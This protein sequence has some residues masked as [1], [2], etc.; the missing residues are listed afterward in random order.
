M[1][2]VIMAM[3]RPLFMLINSAI[4][5][6]ASASDYFDVIFHGLPL[7]FAVAGYLSIIPGILGIASPWLTREFS[8]LCLS[9]W[10]YITCLLIVLSFL[11]DTVLYPFWGAK[12]DVTPFYYFISSP[13]AAFAG[14]EIWQVVALFL[15]LFLFSTILF[16]LYRWLVILP[17]WTPARRR[18]LPPP[19][20]ESIVMLVATALLIIPIR[21]GFSVSTNNLSRAYYCNNV[22][23]NHAAV[24]PLFSF[25]Y[26]AAHQNN[27][28]SLYRFMPDDEADAILRSISSPDVTHLPAD[29]LLSVTRPDVYIVLMESF[30]S[31]IVPSQ[32]GER[33]AL[34]IDSLASEGLLF[35]GIYASSFRTDRG[36]PAVLS[37]YPGTPTTSIMR[38]TEKTD[39]MPAIPR[40]L[41][42]AGYTSTYF[43]GGDGQFNNRQAYLLGSEVDRILDVRDFSDDIPKGKWGVPDHYLIDRVKQEVA[44]PYDSSSPRLTIVQTSSSHEPFDVP[45][46]LPEGMDKRVNAFIY[47]DSAITSLVRFL[48]ADSARWAN[49]LVILVPDHQGSYPDVTPD[50][51]ITRHHIPLV[52]TGG[53]LRPRGVVSTIGSQTD[54]AATLM[55]MLGLPYSDFTFSRPLLTV[56]DVPGAAFFSRPSE[57]G[58]ITPEGMVVINCDADRLEVSEPVSAPVDSLTRL[59]KGY[60]QALYTDVSRR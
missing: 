25:L 51:F 38:Y 29:S 2:V 17:A 45:R 47:A 40:S 26:S 50:D 1:T 18:H 24:N 12:L 31:A 19:A 13:K 44:A 37:G 49:S 52:M 33:I 7:D 28:G 5:S 3:E 15:A 60:L 21:G 16:L 59:A 23:L 43:Q 27:F 8:R 4:Y 6:S 30:S 58:I 35:D 11:T 39:R 41:K 46:A 10:C 54:I 56:E 36:I 57:A 9:I 55:T 42:S 32:G 14:I 48:E 34:G 53:A 20:S 22:S